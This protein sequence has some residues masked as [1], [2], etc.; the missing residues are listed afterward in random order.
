MFRSSRYTLLAALLF[1]AV[2]P[3]FLNLG[4]SSIWDAN[5]A[6]YAQTPREMMEAGD[7]VT[8]TFNFQL[9]VNKPVLSYW[10]VAGAYHLFGVSEWSERV[11]VALGGLVI[12]GTAF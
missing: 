11:P 4:V 9:R 5:E 6:F 3:Y 10:H 2:L 12:V 7:Y 8:P 1:A